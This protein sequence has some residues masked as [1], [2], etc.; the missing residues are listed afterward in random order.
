MVDIESAARVRPA[1]MSI[2]TTSLHAL[3]RLLVVV[4]PERGGESGARAA[5]LD[6]AAESAARVRPASMSI[7]TTSLHALR[8][9]LIVVRPSAA[10]SAARV[11]PA[12]MSINTTSLHALRRLLVVVRPE[13][14]GE[15]G[16]RAARLDEYQHY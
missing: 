10:E 16:A 11:R 15:R 6:D 7:N 2:N 8:R 13:R 14:G 9:L 4:R 3:R 12:S 1:S 5:R